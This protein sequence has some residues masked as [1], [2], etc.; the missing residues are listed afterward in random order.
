ML[1]IDDGYD[2]LRGCD[3]NRFGFDCWDAAAAATK[4]V[5]FHV[6]PVVAVAADAD[7]DALT[8]YQRASAALISWALLL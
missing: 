6:S 7:A 8:E 1:Q 3:K 4:L 2:S 5:V